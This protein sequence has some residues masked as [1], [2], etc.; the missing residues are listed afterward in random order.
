MSETEEE[1][2]TRL[3]KALKQASAVESKT[4]NP[5]ERKSKLKELIPEVDTN[6]PDGYEPMSKVF[7]VE[8][9]GRDVPCRVRKDEEF[10]EHLRM[11]IPK[12]IEGYIWP[13]E[14]LE[15]ALLGLEHNDRVLLHG[16]AGTGK[17]SLF[18]QICAYLNIPFM[19]V[20][21]REDMESSAIFGSIHV[22][23]GT[24]TWVPGP[25]DELGRHGG[26]LQVD[27][28][29][30]APPGINMAM[31]WMLEDDGK[32]FLADKPGK[33]S[34][35]IIHPVS[36][37]HLVATD[38]TRLQ[39]DTMG[40]FAGTQVQNSAMLDRFNN[41]IPL[42]YPPK[43]S[44]EAMLT[45]RVTEIKPDLAHKMVQVAGHIRAAFKEGSIQYPLSP[46]ANIEWA[47]KIVQMG[48]IE[49]AFKTV[50]FNKL[51]DDDRK[52]VEGYYQR[53]FPDAQL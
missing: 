42:D 53:I 30:A 39:G 50:Y 1:Y 41:V 21:C 16:E 19:R 40:T 18:E 51:L 7:S 6:T 10:P 49:N 43:K 38:N 9:K 20:N 31:Q 22:E 12:K 45:S 28:I 14:A 17:S 47:R 3:A 52:Q 34:E 37:F 13:V 29:S 36:D 33:P 24:I 2:R 48:S 44:E 15:A 11:F 8:A 35:K 27:E 23:E 4:Q 5:E 25:A 26:V 32:I 46:R